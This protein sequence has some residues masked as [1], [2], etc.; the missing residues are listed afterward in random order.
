MAPSFFII[1]E[2]VLSRGLIELQV[3]GKTKPFHV[4]RGC[5]SISH[6]LFADDTLIL[7][8]V[9]KQ[10]LNNLMKFLNRYEKASGQRIHREKSCFVSGK[11]VA[12]SRNHIISAT[13]GFSKKSLPMQYLGVPLFA[14]KARYSKGL[15]EKIQRRISTF[16]CNQ[17]SKGGRI[18]LLQSVFASIPLLS[19][20]TPPRQTIGR[21]QRLFSN[22]RS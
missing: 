15:V 9:T 1:A 21:L 16:L 8:N 17:L 5:P 18:V 2:E 22:F 13:T 10:S 12:P 11:H 14:A 7:T 3:R 6:F 19:S 4:P 20:M